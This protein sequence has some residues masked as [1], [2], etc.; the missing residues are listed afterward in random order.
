MLREPLPFSLR[1]TTV[2]REMLDL[3]SCKSPGRSP[4]VAFNQISLLFNPYRAF[5]CSRHRLFETFI[6]PLACLTL[7]AGRS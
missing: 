6:V 4:I 2:Y 7:P 5:S 1:S 3:R